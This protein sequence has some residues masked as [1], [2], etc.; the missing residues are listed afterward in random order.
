MINLT[1]F[2]ETEFCNEHSMIGGAAAGDGDRVSKREVASS[3]RLGIVC[4][5]GHNNVG[6]GSSVVD[7]DDQLPGKREQR[8][9]TVPT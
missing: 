2:V 9:R 3:E 8:I 7:V 1:P 5:V 6:V 4:G